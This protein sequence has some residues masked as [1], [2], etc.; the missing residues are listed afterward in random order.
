MDE[1]LRLREPAC[2]A[3]SNLAF[4][5]WHDFYFD[6]R[7]QRIIDWKQR[8]VVV[9]VTRRDGVFVWS[10]EWF[11]ALL[12]RTGNVQPA[13]FMNRCIETRRW[14]QLEILCMLARVLEAQLILKEERLLSIRRDFNRKPGKI[15]SLFLRQIKREQR[16]GIAAIRFHGHAILRRLGG[17]FR[18]HG[19]S[20]GVRV[21]MAQ[22]SC[23]Q[24]IL[25]SALYD[26]RS[27]GF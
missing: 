21:V 25:N 20:P 1:G 22:Y 24:R 18:G 7:T 4:R 2:E 12:Q 27:G 19:G 16:L 23:G 10:K 11:D 8:A 9:E 3:E 6:C 15:L 14:R 5:K 13:E 17:F 26:K